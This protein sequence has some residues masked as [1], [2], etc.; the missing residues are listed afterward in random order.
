MGQKAGK[1]TKD[2]VELLRQNARHLQ[3]AQGD[4]Q[5]GQGQG[6][7]QGQATKPAKKETHSCPNTQMQ[8]S[9]PAPKADAI[10]PG[11][12]QTICLGQII[13]LGRTGL[14]QSALR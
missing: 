8:T 6:Q 14:H 7:G 1:Q 3:M 5:P 11:L 9:A 10:V 12:G 13:C 4:R 2:A